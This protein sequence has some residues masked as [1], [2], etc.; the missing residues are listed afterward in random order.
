[1]PLVIVLGII[2]VLLFFMWISIGREP[3]PG[4]EDVAI[5][6]ETAWAELDFD[7][8]FS[9]S[10]PELRDGLRRERFIAVKRKAYASAGKAKR[11]GAH[12]EVETSVVGNQTA[13][14]VTEVSVDGGAVRNNVMLD[15]SA[16]GW[17]VVSY[18]LR[19]DSQ[20]APPTST[21]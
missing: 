8:L 12:V 13:L 17:L 21:A 5:A 19:A 20:I 16:N 14:V 6:Y 3:G 10:G 2:V 18:S 7:L 11:I 9:L 15:H 1:M 4:P